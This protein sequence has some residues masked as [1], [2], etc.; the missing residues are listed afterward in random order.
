MKVKVCGL[1]N[2]ADILS[3]AQ[4]GADF[5]GFN[6]Y[7]QSSRYV[8]PALDPSFCATLGKLF[9]DVKKTG[10]FVNASEEEVDATIALFGLNAVQFHGDEPEAYCRS[11]MSY[12]TVIKAVQ[13][14]CA[15]DITGLA[16]Y[17]KCCHLLLLDTA[18]VQRGGSG[19]KFNW[20]LLSDYSANIPFI[21][22]GGIG[23]ADADAIHSL[24]HP[25]LAG[26]DINSRFEISPGQK[27]CPAI[28]KFIKQL[29][30]ANI[31]TA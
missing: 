27:D 16:R 14:K 31:R 15:D 8:L 6:F 24:A 2:R 5:I 18:S 26:V 11:F 17:A 29:H 23:P 7:A 28:T 13:V 22:A 4:S 12:I 19:E 10:V 25:M 9:P 21:L 1:R 3:V 30:N 20:E